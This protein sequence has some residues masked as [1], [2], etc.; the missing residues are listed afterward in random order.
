MKVNSIMLDFLKGKYFSN[1]QSF[2]F[3]SENKELINLIQYIHTNL[4]EKRVIHV[5]ACD[6]INLIDQKIKNNIY[7]HKIITEVAQ[8]CYGIDIEK[9]VI[10][11]LSENYCINNIYYYDVIKGENLPFH[12]SDKFDYLLLFDVIE[13]IG[14]PVSFIQQIKN[15]F[16]GKVEKVVITVPNAFVLNNVK[17]IFKNIEL[18]NT[19]HRFWFTIYTI[20]KVLTDAGINVE[21]IIFINRYYVPKKNVFLKFILKKF[22]LLRD[23]ILVEGRL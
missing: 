8:I 4:K 16:I 19:D 9:E 13:H 20:S 12:I 7:L 6:H 11:Y 14:D 3:E 22:P 5:G 2:K 23:T 17:N 15:I 10:K 18:V 21:N 1:G